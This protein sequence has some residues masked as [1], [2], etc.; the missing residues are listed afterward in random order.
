MQ[1]APFATLRPGVGVALLGV[2]AAM[3][4]VVASAPADAQSAAGQNPGSQNPVSQNPGS[5]NPGSQKAGSQ[6]PGPRPATAAQPKQPGPNQPAANVAPSTP[7]G[8][9]GIWFDDTGKGAVEIKPCGA[10]LCGNIVWMAQPLGADG[11]LQ[12]DGYNPDKAKRNQ[13]VCGLQVLGDVMP[14]PDGTWDRGW[15]YDPKVG[16]SFDVAF[17]LD[18]KDR[19]KVT[20]YK[21]VKFLSKTFLWTRANV[22]L[23]RCDGVVSNLPPLPPSTPSRS[24]PSRSPGAGAAP[25]AKSTPPTATQRATVPIQQP[26][27]RP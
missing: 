3:A 10:N 17:A 11:L 8:P 25:V 24:T 20:G 27:L 5:Q 1:L 12:N 7:V 21:G 16:K 14:Q 9:I 15:V 26:A 18:A 23:P 19:L 6:N 2:F 22:P 13:P 4:N